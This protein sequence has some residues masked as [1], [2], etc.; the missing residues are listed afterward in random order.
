MRP[1]PTRGRYGPAIP[2]TADRCFVCYVTFHPI[3]LPYEY[4][5]EDLWPGIQGE[6]EGTLHGTMIFH[7]D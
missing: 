1:G 7:D 6:P 5:P 3:L 2:K 4:I